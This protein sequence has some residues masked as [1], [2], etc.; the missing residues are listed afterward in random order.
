MA[1]KIVT[2]PAAEPVSLVEIKLH[3]RLDA[4]DDTEDDL[5]TALIKSARE[6]IESYTRRALVT[7]TWDYFLEGL[8]EGDEIWLPYPPLQSVTSLKYRDTDGNETTWDSSN[9]IVDT[10]S[11]IGRIKLAYG[12]SWFTDTLYPANPITVRFVCG[13]GDADEVPVG[14]KSAVKLLVAHWYEHR[15]A[16]VS[17]NEAPY[18]IP[19]TVDALLYPFRVFGF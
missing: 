9:Y 7:Q 5:L 8:P 13:Y 3:L 19:F 2:A 12:V 17:K 16:V 10:N 15:E 11:F 14:I 1:S 6:Y 18:N 4:N